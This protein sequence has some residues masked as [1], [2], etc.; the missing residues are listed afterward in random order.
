MPILET[1][2]LI[3]ALFAAMACIGAFLS[4]AS[5]FDIMVVLALVIFAPPL[6]VLLIAAMVITGFVSPRRMAVNQSF[7]RAGW[8]ARVHVPRRTTFSGR[9]RRY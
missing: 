9:S 7:G 8:P 1:I 3:A 5:P 4:V 2:V 6:G